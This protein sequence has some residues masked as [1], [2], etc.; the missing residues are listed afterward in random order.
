MTESQTGGVTPM[1][2]AGRMVSERERLVGMSAEERAWR[3]QWLKDQRLAP[4]EPVHVPELNKLNPI[5]RFYSA[6]LNKVE[7]IL[8]PVLVRLITAQF[9]CVNI[10]FPSMLHNNKH[11]TGV[12]HY[13]FCG[14]VLVD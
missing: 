2:I 6:P 7:T 13:T 11:E 4:H 9:R 3:A 8:K 14:N 10:Q 12:R 5:R 1:A